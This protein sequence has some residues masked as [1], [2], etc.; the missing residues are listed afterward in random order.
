MIGARS[1]SDWKM[2]LRVLLN[3][4]ADGDVPEIMVTGLADDSR[5][6][7]AGSLFMAAAGLQ[8]H[9]LEFVEQAQA[10][11][12]VAIAYEP[13]PGLTPPPGAIPVPGLARRRGQIAARFYEHPTRKLRVC[14]V[15]GT[16]GKT[17]VVHLVSRAS[18]LLNLQC[19][20]MGTLG[21][22]LSDPLTPSALT[23]PDVV[24]THKRLAFMQAQGA[25]HVAMEVS[26]H[27]LH[28]GR[29]DAV[30]FDTAVFT[31]VSRDHLDYHEDMT[32]YVKTKQL[33][34]AWPGL[35]H[36][37]LNVDDK[38]VGITA[39]ALPP[40]VQLTTVGEHAADVKGAT[41][42]LRADRV[43]TTADG[44]ELDV[45]SNLGSVTLRSPLLGDF[46]SVNLLQALGVLVSWGVAFEKA[47]SALGG[48][49]PPAGRMEMHGG[50]DRPLMVI[51]YAHT[52]DALANALAALRAHCSGRLICVFGCGGDRDRGKRALMAKS[53]ACADH[54][55]VTDD[56]PRHEDPERIVA[57]I[58]AGFDADASFEIERDRR[59]AVA[60]AADIAQAGDVVLVAG[61]GHERVQIQGSNTIQMAD[62][63]LVQQALSVS[64]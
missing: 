25:R 27:A 9:G 26:S 44:I 47:A 13:V 24:T 35:R 32:H 15:T 12:A 34:F 31:N 43:V 4:I 20:H 39:R 1:A 2:S 63:D 8:R 38:T 30:L 10:A 40:R 17:T 50:Q 42:W 7:R 16:N 41:N 52:P 6:V 29:V 48:V 53:S 64:P 60:R 3:S 19:A 28:Q 57:D 46:N 36:A 56:N 21:F 14:G 55:I 45:V 54:V 5:Q 33:L 58:V 18:R 62:R 22:G 59:A 11:G 23:T 49:A 37:V 51:D 61:K